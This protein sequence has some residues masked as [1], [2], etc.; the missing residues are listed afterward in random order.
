MKCQRL[1]TYYCALC[2][3]PSFPYMLAPLCVLVTFLAVFHPHP[4]QSFGY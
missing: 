3:S 4:T 2:C 1:F